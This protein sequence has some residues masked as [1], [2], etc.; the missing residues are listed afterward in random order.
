MS[1]DFDEDVESTKRVE[2]RIS[3]KELLALAAIGG[4]VVVRQLWLR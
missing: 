4:L 3:W 2:R 1:F